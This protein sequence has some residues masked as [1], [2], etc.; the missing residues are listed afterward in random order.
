MFDIM[1]SIVPVIVIVG[2]VAVFV[3]IFA[4]VIHSAKEYKTNK[5]SP[6]LTVD[7]RVAAKRM[8]VQ[9]H[10]HNTGEHFFT[11]TN[12]VYYATFEVASGDRMEFRVS[13]EEYGMLA[14]GDAGKL[15]FQG[16]RYQGFVRV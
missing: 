1:F 8:D 7:A 14:E 4:R 13:A 16:T 11:S 9:H 10:S 3:M 2:F 15:T 12:T 5:A 6:V